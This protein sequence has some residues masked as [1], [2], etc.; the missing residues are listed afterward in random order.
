MSSSRVDQRC[1][2]AEPEYRRL[3]C[4]SSDSETRRAVV[5][6]RHAD[7]GA[8]AAG[9]DVLRMLSSQGALRPAMVVGIGGA[10]PRADCLIDG[11]L[12]ESGIF[13]ALHRSGRI[14]RLDVVTVFSDTVDG[15]A[16]AEL[17]AAASDMVQRCRQVAAPSAWVWDHRVSVC[18][19]G[20][21]GTAG[22][23]GAPDT[24]I[25]VIGED[26]R[27]PSAMAR[28]LHSAETETFGLHVAV[29]LAS[30]CGLWEACD[31]A[32]LAQIRFAA[33]G[34]DTPLVMLARSVVRTA[35]LALPAFAEAI[36]QGDTL[37][38]PAGARR[39]PIP[40][41]MTRMAAARLYPEELRFKQLEVAAPSEDAEPSF[42][43]R[44]GPR[45]LR[46]L[47]LFPKRLRNTGSSEMSSALDE[48]VHRMRDPTPRLQNEPDPAIE[49]KPLRPQDCG[50]GT[51]PVEVYRPR[52]WN[53]LIRATLAIADGAEH[54]RRI[55]LEESGGSDDVLTSKQNLAADVG[56]SNDIAAVYRSLQ[57]SCCA[58]FQGEKPTAGAVHRVGDGVTGDV[59]TPRGVTGGVESADNDGPETDV[60]V[61]EKNEDLPVPANLPDDDG[62]LLQRLTAEF[63]RERRR[64]RQSVE[65]CHS[66]L[67]AWAAKWEAG[68][69]DVEL[70]KAVPYCVAVGLLLAILTWAVI[71][72]WVPEFDLNSASGWLSRA[73]TLLSAALVMALFILNMPRGI[74]RLQLYL[75]LGSTA[76]LAMT[77]WLLLRSESVERLI[78]MD[79]SGAAP[80]LM[81]LMLALMGA[82]TW[83]L[84]TRADR[85]RSTHR[86][87][88]ALVSAYLTVVTVAVLNDESFTQNIS[89][90]S[91]PSSTLLIVPSVVAVSLIATSFVVV[92]ILYHRHEL[93]R[94]Q[95]REE[96]RWLEHWHD[97]THRR[98]SAQAAVLVHWLG[99][100]M[101]LH[102][103]FRH[104]FGAPQQ[105]PGSKSSP[106]GSSRLT[107]ASADPETPGA[108]DGETVRTHASALM[109]FVSCELE[110][111]EKGRQ[112]FSRL[113]RSELA[114]PGWLYAQYTR[115][116]EAHRRA[117]STGTVGL[118]D[119][120]TP[121]ECAYPYKLDDGVL[122]T[123]DGDRWP[124][125]QEL[126][127]GDFDE[128]L[129]ARVT[130]FVAGEGLN[131]TF[132]DLDAFSVV[133]GAH[134]E[135]SPLDLLAEIATDPDPEIPQGVLSDAAVDLSDEE[136]R[137]RS[138]LWWPQRLAAP[139]DGINIAETRSFKLR[140]SVVHLAVRVD[141]S[142]PVPLTAVAGGTQPASHDHAVG[143]PDR[144]EPRPDRAEATHEP[145]I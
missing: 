36:Q 106:E 48:M 144:S 35:R 8:V 20:S 33:S 67:R 128:L 131:E 111:T 2:I 95:R 47:R 16:G 117:G 112:N 143:S 9:I 85:V 11:D 115:A 82:S 50:L 55:R 72:R 99:T 28:P 86:V 60:S 21:F 68:A 39:T 44:L 94:R 110:L 22:F 135:Q 40:D 41:E 62:D 126:Y 113:L 98:E 84:I 51:R 49:A 59:S 145:L 23:G 140:D 63:E 37:P 34:T 43:Q 97:E 119:R 70:S 52:M 130:E 78:S 101:A 30:L 81:M 92:S 57:D 42:A 24:R 139:T 71:P 65:A 138:Y 123:A 77:T 124:F 14:D 53:D 27:F 17:A 10:D 69:P 87:S 107:N 121:H 120:G 129:V 91:D 83:T 103:L 125:V 3:G 118:G 141:L 89:F 105:L 142:E 75:I 127:R 100:A 56:G 38:V 54:A 133:S 25:V 104:P 93:E 31:D 58:E 80:L 64:A 61:A 13:D 136:R 12:V 1:S 116:A 109:K 137:M 4:L 76:I 7:D 6:V 73:W 79:A 88:A 114:G 74:K 5:V 29:E 19:Y 26:R 102:R 134:T 46:D 18:S 108:S 96:L 15:P 132:G 90:L 122:T 45:L 66:R 32:P